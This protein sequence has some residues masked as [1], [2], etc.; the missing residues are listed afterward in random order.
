MGGVMRENVEDPQSDVLIVLNCKSRERILGR[1]SHREGQSQCYPQTAQ[2]RSVETQVSAMEFCEF[3]GDPQTESEPR[4]GFINP[5][6][7]L[8]NKWNLIRP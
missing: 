7:G 6:T 5:L 1:C 4:R 8:E 2:R 3:A